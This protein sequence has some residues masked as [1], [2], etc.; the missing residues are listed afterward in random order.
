MKKITSATNPFIKRVVKLHTAQ[1]RAQVKQ[2]II[3]GKRSLATARE[4]LSLDTLFCTEQQLS[5]AQTIAAEYKIIIVPDSLMKK[6]S[7]TKSPSGLLGIFTIPPTP[8]PDQLSPGLVCAQI[9]DPG[10]MGTLIRTAVA[11]NISSIV[12]IEGADP[13]SPKVIHASAGTIAQVQL[14]QWSWEELL[15]YKK[16]LQLYALV[17]QGGKPPST[18]EK[19]QALLV[20]GNEAHGIPSEWINDCDEMITLSMPGATESLNAAVAGSI[21]LY[22]SFIQP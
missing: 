2:C 5:V 18:I 9:H 21:T 19:S 17:V 15:T 12:I 20:V 14:F 22:L 8:E 10:N 1:E 4:K 6:I 11:C 7:T 3:E 16:N 13:W